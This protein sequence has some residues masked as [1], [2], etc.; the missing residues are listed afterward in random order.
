MVSENAHLGSNRGS[1]SAP[2]RE[3][4][5]QTPVVQN[6]IIDPFKDP[7]KGNPILIIQALYY[8][9]L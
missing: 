8:R 9:T 4:M 6:P 3:P 7:F 2:A 1:I 5:D